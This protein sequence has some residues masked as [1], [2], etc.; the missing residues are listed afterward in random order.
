MS[1]KKRV[2]EEEDNFLTKLRSHLKVLAQ[3]L[4]FKHKTLGIQLNSEFV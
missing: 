2:N 3:V 1:S 4:K